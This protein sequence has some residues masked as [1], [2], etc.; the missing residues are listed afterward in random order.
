MVEAT[1]ATGAP[2]DSSAPSETIAS[3]EPIKPKLATPWVT[4][5]LAVANVAVFGWA[6]SAGADVM[7]P[8]AQWMLAHGGNYGPMTLDGQQWRL[9]TSMFMHYGILHLA[10]NMIGLADGGR[11][12]ERMY[13]PAGF[14][15][16][17]LV[18]GLAG[19]F[20]TSLRGNVVSAGASGAIFG[21]FG[22]FGAFLWLHRDRLDKE[23][24]KKQSRGLAIF[25]AYNIYFGVT[26]EGIDLLAHFGGLVAGF[27]CGLALEFGTT[28]DHTTLRRALIVGVLGTG[29]ILGGSM[30]A[31]RANNAMADFATIETK[32][33]ARWNEAVQQIQAGTLTDD[34]VADL[35]ENELLPQW[36]TARAGYEANGEGKLRALML[37][38]LAVRQ[39][40]WEIMVPGL[41]AG[42]QEVVA[43]GAA[44][45]AEGGGYIQKLKDAAAR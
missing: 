4:I 9:V 25:L 43:R 19:S 39:E 11:H 10:M 44:K 32:V 31:P 36:R 24:V 23:E 41:R 6:L 17:Y 42:D 14:I 34:K 21:V 29:L 28:H 40:G 20:A 8:D 15:A 27:L 35:I 18:A 45:F 22:A 7:S 26:A 1:A 2:S 12:V 16:L 38:Y 5:V 33:L 37:Q 13:G 3:S 30:L